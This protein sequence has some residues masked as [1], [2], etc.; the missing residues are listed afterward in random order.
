MENNQWFNDRA[1]EEWHNQ[2][3]GGDGNSL[4]NIPLHQACKYIT[5]H[6]ICQTYQA[7][8]NNGDG[9]AA[10][11]AVST[12][13]NQESIPVPSAY[14]LV[15]QCCGDNPITAPNC[16]VIQNGWC[17]KYS[18]AQASGNPAQI[19]TEIQ[20]LATAYAITTQVAL[21]LFTNCCS[22]NS[23]GEPC[24]PSD[25]NS[26]FYTTD[27]FCNSDYC[28]YGNNHPDCRCCDNGSNTNT[29]ELDVSPWC[30]EYVIAVDSADF[31]GMQTII[32]A[33]TTT[34]SISWIQASQLLYDQCVCPDNG[35]GNTGNPDC[36]DKNWLSMPLGTS[37]SGQK[38]N[39]CERCA[40]QSG[41]SSANQGNFPVDIYGGNWQYNANSGT[42]YCSCCEDTNTNTQADILRYRCDAGGCLQC[43]AGTSASVCPHTESTCANSCSTNP[44]DDFQDN[45]CCAKC[46]PYI[47]QGHPC[48]DFC[49][50][51]GDC[52]SGSNNGGGIQAK[53]GSNSNPIGM[54]SMQGQAIYGNFNGPLN[55]F[56]QGDFLTDQPGDT[57]SM[58]D[59]INDVP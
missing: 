16:D 33:V 46:D 23:G 43:P 21:D 25:P 41:V 5:S 19:Q 22:D 49:Q 15:L 26:P 27:Q 55:T 53:A 51:Y 47:T 37:S 2:I 34:F 12:F 9:Q 29:G 6:G 10:M 44:C 30:N 1:G 28:N 58:D 57:Q 40:G 31:S 59:F 17:Q 35:T 18:Q 24:P 20:N 32:S 14:N 36:K 48:Y 50:Q 39:Y 4:I 3:G 11:Q 8:I 52:C 13:A 38:K 42:N 45:G 56:K 7:H 54:G